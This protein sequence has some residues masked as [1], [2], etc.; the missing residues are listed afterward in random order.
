MRLSPANY[1]THVPRTLKENLL[2]RKR[3]IEWVSKG[4]EDGT[5]KARRQAVIRMC[6]DDILFYINVFVWQFNPKGKTFAERAAP[7][8]TW[9]FQEAS[10]MARPEDPR[11]GGRFCPW[12]YD[13]GILWCYENDR[14]SVC[15]KSRE[16]GVTWEFLI[17]E[18]WLA[19][20]HDLIQALNISRDADSVDSKSPDSLFS[21]LRY[22]HKH[23]PD[24]MPGP[25]PKSGKMYFEFPR[26]GSTITGEASTG[27]AGVGGR[28]ALIFPDEFP[29]CE[30]AADIRERTAGTSDCRFFNGTHQGTDTEF[31]KLTQTPEIV[32]FTMHWTQHPKK[33][34]GL[35]RSGIG[36]LGYEVLDTTYQYPPDFKFVT[37]GT[38]SGGP[39]P[40]IRSPWYDKKCKEIGDSRGIAR[41]LDI[42]PSGSVSQ[43]AD[44]LVIQKLIVDHCRPGWRGEITYDREL[45]I[46]DEL[47]PTAGGNLELWCKLDENNRPE[48]DI[49]KMGIDPSTGSGATPSCISIM[50]QR[51]GEKVGQF[52]S[53]SFGEIELAPLAVAIARCFCDEYENPAQM[54]WEIPGPGQKFGFK[55][56]ELG[57]RNIYYRTD[58]NKPYARPKA[59]IPGWL[60]NK[61][62]K[63]LL[64]T[65]YYSALKTGRCTNQSES[66]VRELLLFRYEEDGYIYHSN[67]KNAS[68]DPR[69]GRVNHADMAIA[70]GQA[71]MLVKKSGAV[72][73]KKKI[74]EQEARPPAY[75]L[76]WFRKQDELARREREWIEG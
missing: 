37:D 5:L 68:L 58:E 55:V 69:D 25:G 38:P 21:K 60:C 18:D 30:A 52:R 46:F 54:C 59:E 64:I 4:R 71:W 39:Y 50:R 62:T 75:S 29:L 28:A 27:K 22:I 23:M 3:L 57:F 32:Q 61:E 34:P 67:E 65:E 36:K 11:E 13:R 47:V 74:Q 35:Y 73:P 19:K 20:F 45:G 51:T 24:W 42:N 41:E 56:L 33:W 1:H 66:A 12:R 16:M 6:R 14:T 9:D 76:A 43:F 49:Y 2:Y 48:R 40:G 53:A 17:F 8:I 10:L 15:Q 72:E 63:R 26:S 7:F 31:Y 70:D 44:P